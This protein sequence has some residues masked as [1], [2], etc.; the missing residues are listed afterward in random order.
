MIL[1]LPIAVAIGLMGL[2]ASLFVWIQCASIEAA[3]AIIMCIVTVVVYGLLTLWGVIQSK[4]ADKPYY[5]ISVGIIFVIG[6]LLLAFQSQIVD[7][8][9]SLFA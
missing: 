4:K 2:G 7:F 3:S 1:L 5:L 6:A 8:Y 9:G